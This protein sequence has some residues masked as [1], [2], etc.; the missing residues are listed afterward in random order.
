MQSIQLLALYLE[1]LYQAAEAL[2]A[3]VARAG[4]AE[5][6]PPSPVSTEFD[7]LLA[8]GQEL[9]AWRRRAVSR[10]ELPPAPDASRLGAALAEL[11]PKPTAFP[12][13]PE[14]RPEGDPF[15]W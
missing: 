12:E 9:G 2:D 14:G 13:L 1:R 3:A 15:D 5:V 10:G 8:I 7:R 11:A 4:G 6:L